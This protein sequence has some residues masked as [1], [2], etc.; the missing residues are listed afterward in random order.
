MPKS[1]SE[2]NKLSLSRLFSSGAVQSALASCQLCVAPRSRV[3]EDGDV[4]RRA[5]SSVYPVGTR[6][7]Q[8]HL[9]QTD[10]LDTTNKGTIR[11]E[12]YKHISRWKARSKAKTEVMSAMRLLMGVTYDTM[13]LSN[14]CQK[15]RTYTYTYDIALESANSKSATECSTIITIMPFRNLEL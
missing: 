1:L 2:R 3:T 7:D 10:H 8:L 13:Q 12:G 15:Y 11:N 9:V 4:F 14:L 6:G 5:G